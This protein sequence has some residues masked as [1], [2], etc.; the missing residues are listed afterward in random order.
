MPILRVMRPRKRPRV[1]PRNP[2]KQ[3]AIHLYHAPREG[4]HADDVR[5]ALE[6]LGL[7]APLLRRNPVTCD[8]I[9]LVDFIGRH[10]DDVVAAL[11][12]L[13][14]LWVNRWKGRRIE[15]EAQGLKVKA[16][17]VTEMKRALAVLYKYRRLVVT[18]NNTEGSRS[19]KKKTKAK[20]G[21]ELE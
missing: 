15:I 13:L 12:G 5:E 10:K 1:Q 14:T 19:S 6:G 2:G 17:T 7:K 16:S 4:R 3:L 18:L 20:S 11:I 9:M 8:W 21:K